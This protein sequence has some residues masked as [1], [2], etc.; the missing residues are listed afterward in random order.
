MKFCGKGSVLISA[1][2]HSARFIAPIGL[3]VIVNNNARPC[4]RFSGTRVQASMVD[5]SSD[6]VKRM[7]RAWSIFQCTWLFYFLPRTCLCSKGCTRPIKITD[8]YNIHHAYSNQ[9]QLHVHLATLKGKLN[10]NGVG[11]QVS[12]LLVTMCYV[13]F[14]PET[15]AVLFAKAR[16][17]CA[18]LIVKEQ[19][20]VQSGW[21]NLLLQSSKHTLQLKLRH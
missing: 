20:F 10:V 3:R 21:K 16:D 11:V 6:F 12:S 4:N 1:R 14:H 17:Q 18:A 19:A 7:D 15:L 5:S 13:K 8:F 9:G 2:M